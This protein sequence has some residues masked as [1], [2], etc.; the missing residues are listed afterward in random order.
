MLCDIERGG[1]WGIKGEEI[2][3]KEKKRVVDERD[4]LEDRIG[5]IDD[6]KQSIYS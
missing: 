5:N 4:D 3:I 6:G 2:Y 1:Y